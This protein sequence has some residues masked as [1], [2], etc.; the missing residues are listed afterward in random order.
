MDVR[1]MSGDMGAGD[2]TPGSS[3]FQA[4]CGAV[5]PLVQHLRSNS[6][7][8]LAH[9]FSL[10]MIHTLLRYLMQRYSSRQVGTPFT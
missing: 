10:H 9:T 3:P 2:G 6:H 7:I 4:L 5:F 8:L 1:S